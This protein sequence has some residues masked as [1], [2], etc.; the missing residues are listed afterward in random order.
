MTFSK[1]AISKYAFSIFV[2]IVVAIVT[3]DV[4]TYYT[5]QVLWDEKMDTADQPA[6]PQEASANTHE[7]ISEISHPSV[8]N[9][10]VIRE[11]IYVRDDDGTLLR[12]LDVIYHGLDCPTN[13]DEGC[14]EIR[15]G[16]TLP[17]H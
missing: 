9:E 3:W 14:I 1:Q 15:I 4:S 10:P 5:E 16:T 17:S 12:V 13:D 6:L 2:C 8:S 7:S 11:H